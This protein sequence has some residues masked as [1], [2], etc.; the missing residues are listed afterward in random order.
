MFV[1]GADT[2][3][4][5]LRR[6]RAGDHRATLLA[7]LACAL[8]T[9]AYVMWSPALIVDDWSFAGHAAYDGLAGFDANPGRPLANLW[10]FAE[11]SAL[12]ASPVAHALVLAVINGLAGAGVWLTSRRFLD[13][14]LAVLTTSAWA[15]AANRGSTR[16]WASTAPSVL[17]LIALAAAVLLAAGER[18]TVRRHLTVITLAVGCVLAYEGSAG[19]A[20]GVVTLSAWRWPG[21]TRL[22][23]LGGGGL[24]LTLTAAWTFSQSP[25]TGHVDSFAN[26]GRWI[27]AHL[28][29]GILPDALAPLG[30]AL[31]VLIAWCAATWVLPSFGTT[32]ETRLVVVGTGIALLGALPFLAAGFPVATDGIFDRANVYADLGT[33]LVI[34]AALALV[35][36]AVPARAATVAAVVVLTV[37]ASQNVVDVRAFHQAGV[38]GRRLLRTVDRMPVDVR[39][40]GPLVLPDLPNR[41]GVTMFV[42]DY[43]I[44]AALALRYDTGVPYP[45]AS[46]ALV[47]SRQRTR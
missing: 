28:G 8:P 14:R 22:L 25:K 42:E 18:P 13:G 27:S 4:P 6:I 10:Y 30:L 12:G 29:V 2:L 44:S 21:R 19:L 35:W 16:L 9:L 5:V 45:D 11:F 7:A 1:L 17:V 38:D 41:H 43:D 47:A 24:A 46:M 40:K 34:A 15:V 31:V 33:A 37:L 20:A 32:A 39:T 23:A 36:R 3:P 26:G